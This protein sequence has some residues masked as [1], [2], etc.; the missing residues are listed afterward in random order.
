MD[1]IVAVIHG[2]PIRAQRAETSLLGRIVTA[3][4]RTDKPDCGLTQ[5]ELHVVE[6]T[7]VERSKMRHK[8][9]EQ[10]PL[11]VFC[12]HDSGGRRHERTRCSFSSC[13]KR[14]GVIA[15][16]APSTLSINAMAHVKQQC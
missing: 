5:L 7:D 2:M 14:Y 4:S 11:Q 3:E 13:G 1:G 10:C 8:A 15:T 9:A 16:E 12:I 6:L